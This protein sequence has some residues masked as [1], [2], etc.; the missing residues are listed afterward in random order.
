MA[1]GGVAGTYTGTA[2]IPTAYHIQGRSL[3]LAPPPASASNLT[4]TYWQRIPALGSTMP[5]NWLLEQ[6]PDVYLYGSLIQAEAYIANDERIGL[7]KSAHD[8]AL[9]DL[10]QHGH[11]QQY[12]AG[13]LVPNTVRQVRNVRC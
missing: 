10:I 4:L 13:P 8:E 11:R 6:H 2:G 1:A 5:T 3:V 7:W 9:G 12:G